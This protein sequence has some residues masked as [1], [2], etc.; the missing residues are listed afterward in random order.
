MTPGRLLAI[1]TGFVLFII[2]LVVLLTGGKKPAI[3]NTVQPLPDYA[4][5]DATVSF[6]V[7]G[8]VNADELHRQIRI[9]VSNSQMEMDV[10]QGYNPR[11]IKSKSFVNNQEA[12]T[13]FLKSINNYGFLSKLKGTKE[14]DSEEGQC[15]LGFRYILDLNQDGVDLSRTWASTCGSKVGTSGALIDTIQTLFQDQIPNYQQLT[16]NVNLQATT[17]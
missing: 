15:P 4:G 6:T 16:E 5:T 8:L 17:E 11:V 3:G 9:T 2:I 14:P 1:F 7:D 13:V 10:L 12:Y